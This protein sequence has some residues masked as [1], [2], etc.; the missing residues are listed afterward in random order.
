M[1][2]ALNVR[3]NWNVA[4]NVIIFLG[5]GMGITANTAA[6]IFKGQKKGMNGEEGYMTW[7]RFPNAALLKVGAPAAGGRARTQHIYRLIKYESLPWS[8]R[9]SIVIS[10]MTYG[11][12]NI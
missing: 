3:D 4:K 5:D 10:D 6:R 2:A 11:C 7:E 12:R 9:C 1:A 8:R